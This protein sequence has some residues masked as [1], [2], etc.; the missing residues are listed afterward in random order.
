MM[1]FFVFLL[2]IIAI[3]KFCGCSSNDKKLG[4]ES[5]DELYE[6]ESPVTMENYDTD[7][8]EETYDDES[9][10]DI[11]TEFE[12]TPENNIL[13]RIYSNNKFSIKYPSNW[14]VVQDNTRAT[15]NTTIAVQI[16]Q[17]ETNEYDFRPN[18]NII[19]SKDKY[20][21]S[22]ITLARKSYNQVKDLGIA[23]NLIEIRVCQIDGKEGCVAEYTATVEGYNL[24]IYQYIVKKKDDSTFVITMTLDQTNLRNQKT[25][26][27]QIID[28][29]K[30]F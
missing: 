14:D 20:S 26:S 15:K 25:L 17:R 2:A 23:A 21:E 5:E 13:S 12:V 18:V 29:I 9:E 11:T 19:A 27:Q 22:A 3:I 4:Y 10:I 24:H 8:V 30:I 16:M 6:Y 1:K 28:S 7:I